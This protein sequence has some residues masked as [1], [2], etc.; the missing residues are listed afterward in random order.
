MKR[1]EAIDKAQVKRDELKKTKAWNRAIL[2]AEETK[3]ILTKK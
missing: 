1:Q 3:V 2:K